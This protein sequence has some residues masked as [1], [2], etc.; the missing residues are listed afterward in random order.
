[1]FAQL[2]KP[3]HAEEVEWRIG[4][5][6]KTRGGKI[7]AKAFAYVTNRAIQNR[8]DIPFFERLI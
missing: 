5:S 8:L 7:W 1:M 4:Q 2:R 3:F 6:G